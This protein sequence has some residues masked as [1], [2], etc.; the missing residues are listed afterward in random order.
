MQHLE[1]QIPM[2]Q[3]HPTPNQCDRAE[4]CGSH[5]TLRL[6]SEFILPYSE[7]PTLKIP[8]LRLVPILFQKNENGQL[9]S[10]TIPYHDQYN[11]GHD[12][13][14]YWSILVL[15]IDHDIDRGDPVGFLWSS[16]GVLVE[17]LWSLE[18]CGDRVGFLWSFEPCGDTVEFRILR[19]CCGVP[20]DINIGLDIGCNIGL[21]IDHD[22]G[23]Y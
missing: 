4:N 17:F 8:I 19:R 12:T 23:R 13:G 22:I 7:D 3:P 6:R 10:L 14:R 5:K 1:T 2:S 20:F 15:N 16:C 9:G 11:I 21:D 18:S